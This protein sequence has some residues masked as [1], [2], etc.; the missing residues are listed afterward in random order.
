LEPGTVKELR[1]GQSI[2]FAQPTSNTQADPMLKFDLQSIASGLGITYDQIQGDLSQ[3]NYSS[4]RAGKLEFRALI[5]QLQQHVIIPLLCQRVWDRFI[6]RA[7][8]AGFLRERQDGYRVHWVTPAWEP[9][10]PEKDLDADVR[11]V[12]AGRMTPQEFIAASGGNWHQ[13]LEQFEDFFKEADKLGLAFDIDTRKVDIHGR[14]PTK[15]TEAESELEAQK[16]DDAESE[17]KANEDA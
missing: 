4:L 14:Q 15:R 8:L 2:S 6:S 11:A 17:A 9:V 3:A 10:D 13:S 12:R 7:I 16:D 1:S 5:S